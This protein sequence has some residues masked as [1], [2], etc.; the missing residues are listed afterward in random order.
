MARKYGMPYKGSKN[1]IAEKLIEVLPPAEHFYDLF[2]GGGAITHCALLSGKYKHVHYNEIDPLISKAF[3]MAIHGEFKNET[4]WISREDFNRLKDTDPYVAICFSFGNDLKTYAYAKEKEPF[5]RAVHNFLFFNDKSEIERYVPIDFE[6]T[7]DDVNTKRL[8]F[9]R[10]LKPHIDKIK[11]Y[12]NCDSENPRNVLQSLEGLER[13]NNLNDIKN[14]VCTNLSYDELDFETDSVIYCDI[15]YKETNQYKTE[16][17]YER[18]YKWAEQQDNIFISEY[19]MPDNFIELYSFKRHI[20]MSANKKSHGK[21]ERLFTNRKT[22]EL[23]NC[24]NHVLW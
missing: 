12:C 23:L 9:Q 3:G 1:A 16:F 22:F 15:P 11:S 18:F 7:S 4:R 24:N 5:K 2:G 20:T 6:F 17:D 14:I 8:E 10:Y 21:N 19:E 13:L